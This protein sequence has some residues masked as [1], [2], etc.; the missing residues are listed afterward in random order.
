MEGLFDFGG[1][2]IRIFR[3]F[4]EARALM[5]ADKFDEGAGI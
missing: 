1:A 4:A 3:V 2:H 5:I